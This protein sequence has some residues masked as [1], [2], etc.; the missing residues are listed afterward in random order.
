MKRFILIIALFTVII[1]A[2]TEKSNT[3]E[4]SKDEVI[5]NIIEPGNGIYVIAVKNVN[6][7]ELQNKNY[8]AIHK[9]N[10][11][12]LKIERYN[13]KGNLSDDFSVA[14]VTKFEYDSNGHVK[15]LKYFN[16]DGKPGINS[17]FGYSSIEYIYDDQN[18]VIMEI[19]RDV[20]SK[21]LEIPRD[22][23]GDIAKVNFLSPILAYEYVG[24]ELKIKALDKNLNLLKEVYGDKPCVPFIDCG[25]SER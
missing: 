20:N 16:K 15:Y 6:Q 17:E 25:E 24:D 22:N 23:L 14:A 12:I 1:F 13:N 3:N 2:C 4:L 19:Y 8:E 11:R 7:Q 21:L 5:F 9:Q 10:D 18:R